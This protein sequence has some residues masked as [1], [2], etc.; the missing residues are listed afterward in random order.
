MAVM[1]DLPRWPWWARGSMW[2]SA[3]LSSGACVDDG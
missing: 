3:G 1:P 2:A